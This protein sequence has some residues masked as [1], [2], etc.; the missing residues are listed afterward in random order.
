MPKTGK[1]DGRRVVKARVPRMRTAFFSREIP[2][3]LSA[4]SCRDRV[5]VERQMDKHVFDSRLVLGV[6]CRCRWGYPQTIACRPL[7]KQRP[8]PTLFWL[9]CPYLS[10]L[11]GTIESCGGV[12]DMEEYL[13]KREKSYNDYNRSYALMRLSLLSIAEKRVLRRYMPK[14]WHVLIRT[15]IGGIAMSEK[16]TVKCLHLQTAAYLSLPG[17]P[18]GGWLSER[19]GQ[20]NCDNRQCHIYPRKY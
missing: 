16:P 10:H 18:G 6:S 8:F 7:Y 19:I 4:F 5:I 1:A 3:N 2:A 14:L 9:T 12:H 17:H 20:F 15:G 13:A 11:C